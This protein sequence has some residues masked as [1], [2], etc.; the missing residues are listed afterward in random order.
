MS[1][2]LTS[3]NFDKN[4][5]Q[6]NVDDDYKLI[7]GFSQ[8]C[9]NSRTFLKTA[10]EAELKYGKINLLTN[11]DFLVNMAKKLS[12]QKSLKVPVILLYKNGEFVK[13]ISNTL[14]LTKIQA[15]MDEMTDSEDEIEV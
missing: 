12:I 15:E 6:V 4:I 7:V 13:R 14:S 3:A 11:R 5:S 8:K 9:R 10:D 2:E 1:V